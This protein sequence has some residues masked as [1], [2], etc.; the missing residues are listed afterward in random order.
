MGIFLEFD[1]GK[2]GKIVLKWT[3]STNPYLNCFSYQRLIMRNVEPKPELRIVSLSVSP[4]NLILKGGAFIDF[5]TP[6][7]RL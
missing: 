3:L 1:I 4:A 2:V 6:Q 7:R 5:E